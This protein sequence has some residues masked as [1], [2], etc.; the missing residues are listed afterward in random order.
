MMIVPLTSPVSEGA[1]TS[2][3][4]KALSAVGRWKRYE[5]EP[6]F[7]TICVTGRGGAS[8]GIKIES[9]R[10]GRIRKNPPSSRCRRRRRLSAQYW[11]R[12]GSIA[13]GA[14]WGGGVTGGSLGG[15]GQSDG[16][17]RLVSLPSQ[18]ASPQT[19]PGGGG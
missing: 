11:T 4:Q 12:F 5:P 9:E 7:S 19:S 13:C 18:T 1:E 2:T 8:C 15:A 14:V 6:K 17:L 3:D 16:Q 10:L